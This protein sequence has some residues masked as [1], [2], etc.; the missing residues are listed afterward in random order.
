M[1]ANGDPLVCEN[2]G[3]SSFETSSILASPALIAELREILLSNAPLPPGMEATVRHVIRTAPAELERYDAEIERLQG[4]LSRL[5]SERRALADHLVACR[6]VSTPIRRLPV[7]LLTEI[8]Q[9]SVPSK[10]N[11]MN[12]HASTSGEELDRLA[13]RSLLELSQV[14]SLWHNIV[15]GTPQLWSTIFVDTSRWGEPP[16]SADICLS[17]IRR[18][19]IRSKDCPLVLRVNCSANIS[20]PSVLKLLSKHARRWQDVDLMLPREVTAH[21]KTARGNLP[22]L[23][24]LTFGN[25]FRGVN[26]FKVAPALRKVTFLGRAQGIGSEKR[27]W[28]QLQEFH[29]VGGNGAGSSAALSV[30][31]SLGLGSAFTLDANLEDINATVVWP[32]VVSNIGTLTLVLRASP[33]NVNHCLGQVFDAMTLPHLRRLSFQSGKEYTP[34]IWHQHQFLAFSRRSSLHDHLISLTL[35]ATITDVELLQC[36]SGLPLLEDLTIRSEY[37]TRPNHISFTDTLLQG[38]VLHPEGPSLVPRLHCFSLTSFLRFSDDAYWEFLS[39]RLD[40][41]PGHRRSDQPF[42]IVIRALGYDTRDLGVELSTRISDLVSA[43][44]LKFD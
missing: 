5:A 26:I 29:Y 35:H 3:T 18:S 4:L 1:S 33:S 23:K 30:T 39:S 17:L 15:V 19:L 12:P 27:P 13:K 25:D 2:C 14:S 8:F 32:V 28:P 11:T 9:A 22:L 16:A 44:K 31:R 7:E 41:G 37:I 40:S 34:L 43:G 38:L 21:L 36:L 20:S 24:T 42:R 6:K 10:E